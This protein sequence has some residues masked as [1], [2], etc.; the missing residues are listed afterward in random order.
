[1]SFRYDDRGIRKLQQ[2]LQALQRELNTSVP[3]VELFSPQFMGRHSSYASF[4]AL[5]EASGIHSAEDFE[6][7]SA[8]RRDQMVNEGT[9]F[10]GWDAMLKA[11]GD[12]WLQGKVKEAGLG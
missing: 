7:L 8:E 1:M 2:K 6:S 4:E 11:A 5:L 10:A 9:T 12:A 3:L